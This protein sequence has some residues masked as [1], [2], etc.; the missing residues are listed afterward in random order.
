MMKYRH[1]KLICDVTATYRST[2]YLS[3]TIANLCE[4]DIEML[5]DLAK[6]HGTNQSR[7]C[8]H[9][10]DESSYQSML[11]YHSKSHIVPVHYHTNKD[12]SIHIING[13]AT[14]NVFR[15]N[16]LELIN[17]TVMAAQNNPGN[18]PF[19]TYIPRMTPHELDIKEDI[20]FLESTSG[21]FIKDETV[22]ITKP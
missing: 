8:F 3:D 9:R 20:V 14:L 10:Y 16:D 12:E 17:T 19:F 15:Q 7:I 1:L 5:K 18:H 22:S 6:E 4:Y 21:P 2:Q 13:M 11:V